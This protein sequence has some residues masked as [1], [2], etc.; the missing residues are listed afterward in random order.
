MSQPDDFEVKGKKK[1]KW[2]VNYK[3]PLIDLSKRLDTA[4]EIDEV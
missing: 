3:N 2:Y 1:K 4:F